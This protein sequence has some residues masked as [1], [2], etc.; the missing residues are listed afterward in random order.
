M[1]AAD[2]N[3]SMLRACEVIKSHPRNWNW[4]TNCWASKLFDWHTF[5][6]RP[7]ALHYRKREHLPNRRALPVFRSALLRACTS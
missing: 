7:G 5:A 6:V 4:A 2:D 3:K 1:F